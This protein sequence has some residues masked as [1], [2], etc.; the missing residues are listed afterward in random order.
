MALL[1]LDECTIQLSINSTV[2]GTAMLA[3]DH[4]G[5]SISTSVTVYAPSVMS[6]ES[7]MRAWTSLMPSGADASCSAVYQ[8]TTAS[9]S[10]DGWT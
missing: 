3:V 4:G 8:Q 1:T 6:I 2:N 10:A 5:L 9:A 7:M